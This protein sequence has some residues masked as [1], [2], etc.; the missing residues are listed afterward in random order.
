M[1]E[2]NRMVKPTIISI[3]L[4]T[5]MAAGA[6]SPALHLIASAFPDANPMLVKLILTAPSLMIVPFSFVSGYLINYISKRNLLLIGISIYIIG[7]VSG[8]FA[9]S[10]WILIVLRFLLG[11]GVGLILPLSMSLINDFYTGDERT[12]MMGYNTAFSNFGGI[13]T[14]V[15]AGFLAVYGWKAPFNVYLI[16]LFIMVLVFFFLPDD[17]P[18]RV[19]SKKKKTNIPTIIFVYALGMGTIMLAYFSVA[20]NMA[21]FLEENDLG[22]SRLAGIIISFT[23]I[24]GMV[25]SI[26]LVQI[27]ALFKTYTV[28][29]MLVG[30]NI[31]FFILSFTESIP[32]IMISVCLIGFG[33]GSLFPIIILKALDSVGQ[34]HIERSV[35]IISSFI[36]LGQFLSPIILEAASK[37]FNNETIRFQFGF[38][39]ISFLLYLIIVTSFQMK[40]LVQS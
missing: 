21:I 22:E 17:K 27:Q 12:Q 24:G 8:Q 6:I 10:I 9:Q 34:E 5:V 1:I 30:M 32:L 7:G 4:I 31:A 15:V 39:A 25:T 38:L 23:T 36:F 14:I 13:I 35:A 40:K 20:T 29:V 16:G 33:Q 11:V 37:V 3:S 26:L 18:T 2:I 28:T 19:H